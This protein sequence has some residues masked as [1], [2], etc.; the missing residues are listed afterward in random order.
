MTSLGLLACNGAN[1]SG[2]EPTP[3]EQ[4]SQLQ[5][6]GLLQ[7]LLPVQVRIDLAEGGTAN[8]ELLGFNPET[9]TL[10]LAGLSQGLSLT[11]VDRIERDRD[12]NQG[13]VIARRGNIRGEDT[14]GT[15]TWQVPLNALSSEEATIL[16]IRGEEAW[17]SQALR[18]KLQ[19]Q[20]DVEFVLDEIIPLSADEIQIVVSKVRRGWEE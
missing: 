10:Q 6:Q 13:E 19:L 16:I 9:R 17:D 8:H 3:L 11:E 5:D 15:E 2:T 14:L 20:N 18:V 7:V 12:Q 1:P 4:L